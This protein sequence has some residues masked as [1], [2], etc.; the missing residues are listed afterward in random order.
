MNV[1]SLDF[2][3]ITFADWRKMWI[4][5]LGQSADSMAEGI[6]KHTYMRIRHSKGN[7]LGFLA[8]TDRPVGFAHYYLHPSTYSL[9]D[10]C[11]LEDLYVAPQARGNG[12]GRWLIETVAHR[13]KEA[14][15]SVLNWKT[16][17]SNQSAIA[18]YE[19]IA[20]RTEFLSFR[21]QL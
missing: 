14:G 21:M 8:V 18:L 7:L 13:A 17:P 15:A 20:T 19:K 4:D 16:R 5:Y 3:H 12:I 6:H 1:T 2:E 10:A 11:T 9:T